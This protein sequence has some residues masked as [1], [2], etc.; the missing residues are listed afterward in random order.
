MDEN[1]TDII[2]L[3]H[4]ITNSLVK[5]STKYKENSARSKTLSQETKDLTK[6]H[7]DIKT[8]TNAR[9]K[10]KAVELNNLIRKKQRQD[11]RNFRTNT[12][13]KV[14]QEGRGFKM[15]KRKLNSGKFQ[16][17]GVLE[18]DG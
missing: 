11:F 15:A 12:I 2:E 6:R 3:N 18:G 17:T 14:I 10:I 9:E 16:F 7:R 1:N 5:T 8:P 13:K 4:I